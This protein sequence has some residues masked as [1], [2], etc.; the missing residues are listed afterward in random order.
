MSESKP[1]D[2]TGQWIA[3]QR[4]EILFYVTWIGGAPLGVFLGLHFPSLGWIFGPLWLGG[5]YAAS[6]PIGNFRCPR[7]GKLFF[8]RPVSIGNYYNRFTSKCLNCGLLK[9]QSHE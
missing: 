3:F 9:W 2:Y 1:Q 7:C 6:I 8:S 4:Q 5:S